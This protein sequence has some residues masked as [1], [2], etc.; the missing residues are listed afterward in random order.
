M[1]IVLHILSFRCLPK[2]AKNDYQ[3]RHVCPSVRI[4]EQLDRKYTICVLDN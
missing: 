4:E 3:L 1:T 2:I